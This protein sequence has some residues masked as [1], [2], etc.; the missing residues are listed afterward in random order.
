V[1]TA[2]DISSVL[3]L[4]AVGVFTVQIL[5]GLLLSTGYNPVRR[6]PRRRLKLFTFHNWLGY[7]GLAVACLHP[8]TLLASSTAGFRVFDIVVPIWSPTQP[9]P[10]TLGAVALYLIAFVVLTSY[11]RKVFGHHNWKLLHYTAYAAAAV[12]CG[13]GVMADPTLQKRPIDWIDA[14]QVYVEACAALVLAATAW[15][16][17]HRPALRRNL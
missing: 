13:H 2:I 8:L 17:A 7:I 6:W 11:L 5:L 14:E 10:N 16:V 15:R 1:P 4:I 3:G 12:F 9:L